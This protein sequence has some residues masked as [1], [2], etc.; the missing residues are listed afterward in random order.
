[1][2]RL[3]SQLIKSSFFRTASLFLNVAVSFFLMPFVIRVLGDR[4]Y[5]L[6]VLVGTF[7]GYYGFFD[8]GLS[9]AVQRFVSQAWGKENQEEID[10]IFNTSLVLFTGAGAL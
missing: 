8:F 2:G 9:T 7:V 4:W 10:R 6:W 5:G 1:M 3:A